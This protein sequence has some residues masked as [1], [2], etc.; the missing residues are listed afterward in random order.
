[1]SWDKNT[2][3]DSKAAIYL[4][5]LVKVSDIKTQR[6]VGCRLRKFGELINEAKGLSS[7]LRMVVHKHILRKTRKSLGLDPTIE[8][9][10]R[11]VIVTNSKL[12][13]RISEHKTS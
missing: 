7:R 2:Y 13:L 9:V 4:L 10:L 6:K 12:K 5:D 1:M 3:G 11:N 8:Q